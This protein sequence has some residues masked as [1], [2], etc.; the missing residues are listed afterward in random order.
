MLIHVL[1]SAD[2][3]LV[4]DELHILPLLEPLEAALLPPDVVGG[5][6]VVPASLDVEGGQ[7]HPEPGPRGLNHRLLCL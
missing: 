3:V 2:S 1:Q 4:H 5:E 7:V 6:A